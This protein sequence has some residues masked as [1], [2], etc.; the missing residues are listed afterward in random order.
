MEKTVLIVEDE[1][2][3]GMMLTKR[4]EEYGFT[5]C[6][7]VSTGE[8]ALI[9]AAKLSPG[10]VLM[11]VSLAG[12]MDG[13]EAGAI[14]RSSLGVPVIFFT[15]YQQDRYLMERAMEVQPLAVLDKLGPIEVIIAALNLA[16]P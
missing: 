4:I 8:D 2:L 10:V 13:I 3:V 15:G 1:V 9:A 6:D 14:I 5:V 12:E 7:L 16:F 11:D